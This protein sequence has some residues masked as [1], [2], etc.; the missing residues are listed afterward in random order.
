MVVGVDPLGC[1]WLRVDRRFTNHLQRLV[2]YRHAF[3]T[4][5]DTL[6]N[7]QPYTPNILAIFPLIC[8]EDTEAWIV[9]T[10]LICFD[11]VEWHYPERVVRQFGYHPDV[12][13]LR[14]TDTE[15]HDMDR[16]MK[17]KNYEHLH[18]HRT[19]WWMNR[20]RY[21]LPPKNPYN[22]H[23]SYD[24]PY[25]DWY[26]EHTRLIIS[27]LSSAT[28]RIYEVNHDYYPTAADYSLLGGSITLIFFCLHLTIQLSII[29]LEY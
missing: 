28:E 10:L 16:R 9:K 3:D 25:M 2:M 23:I 21:M 13:P 26:R 12:P 22:G 11:G 15:F 29:W 17:K 27:L 24:D 1:K 7:W 14:D 5:I 20:K 19:D 4:M 8:T 6:F 18:H